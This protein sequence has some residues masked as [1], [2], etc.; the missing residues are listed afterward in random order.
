MARSTDAEPQARLVDVAGAEIKTALRERRIRSLS[1][2][3]GNAIEAT[4]GDIGHI[5]D[6][7]IDTASWSVRY[8]IVH[9]SNWWAGTKVLVS[10]LSICGIDP[11]RG[12]IRLDVSRQK[13]KDSPPYDI[14]QTVDGGYEELFH[15]YYGIRGPRR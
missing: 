9:T 6:V 13:V 7:L 10:P 3:T 12:I 1:E 15:S 2:I 11:V 14:A 5:Q 8:L 4:D